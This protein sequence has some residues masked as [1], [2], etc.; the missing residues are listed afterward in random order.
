LNFFD[1]QLN[2]QMTQVNQSSPSSSISQGGCS[3]QGA[4]NN[5]DGNPNFANY[6]I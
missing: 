3:H 6:A 4:K 1:Q 5:P 2:G